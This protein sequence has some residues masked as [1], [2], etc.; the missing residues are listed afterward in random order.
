MCPCPACTHGCEP[1]ECDR[2]A[3]APCR[4]RAD[5][6][7]RVLEWRSQHPGRLVYDAADVA[8]QLDLVD[9]DFTG[10]D[11]YAI[12]SSL[13]MTERALAT[14]EECLGS[15]C[16]QCHSGTDDTPI[17]SVVMYGRAGE[18]GEPVCPV[19][20]MAAARHSGC[21]ATLRGLLDLESALRMSVATPANDG[22]EPRRATNA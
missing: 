20:M 8:E 9:L 13:L 1:H 11:L 16:E 10:A 22:H 21:P 6:D 3:D 15:G 5:L 17:A 2:H 19:C 18:R 4:W 7:E 14:C 12:T